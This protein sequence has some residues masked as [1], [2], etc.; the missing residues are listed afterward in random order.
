MFCIFDG[1]AA[2]SPATTTSAEDA[3]SCNADDNRSNTLSSPDPAFPASSPSSTA[4]Q[5]EAASTS[6]SA[7]RPSLPRH[8]F[9]IP[10]QNRG[11][12]NSCDVNV[13]LY[14]PRGGN[15]YAEASAK[16]AIKWCKGCKNF[17]PWP[18][19]FGEKR[20]ASKC[21]RCRER[22]RDKYARNRRKNN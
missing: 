14:A 17:K 16:I 6:T 2:S 18:R 11:L 9:T 15:A 10:R 19:A 22:Q 7:Q 13:W 8:H 3:S 20:R 21:A 5:S 1:D 4:S 12:C